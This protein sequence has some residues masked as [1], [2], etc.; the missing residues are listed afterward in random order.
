MIITM[1]TQDCETLHLSYAH[2]KKMEG[3]Q[4]KFLQIISN[5]HV[6][7]QWQDFFHYTELFDMLKLV[8]L[9]EMLIWKKRLMYWSKIMSMNN[10]RLLKKVLFSDAF[11]G[12]RKPGHPLSLGD[13]QS[14]TISRNLTFNI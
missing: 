7:L 10:D 14:F 12:K 6:G 4:Y 3:C 9:I 13:K 5:K 1:L 8:P 2:F 11:E